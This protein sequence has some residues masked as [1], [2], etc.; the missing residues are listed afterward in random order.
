MYKS[1]FKNRG[2]DHEDMSICFLLLHTQN[3]LM[4]DETPGY[5]FWSPASRAKSQGAVE[6]MDIPQPEE[7]LYSE[8][9]IFKIDIQF[10]NKIGIGYEEL[11]QRKDV[12]RILHSMKVP[13]SGRCTMCIDRK[14]HLHGTVK[15]SET[16]WTGVV[17]SVTCRKTHFTYAGKS[18]IWDGVH[19]NQRY[20]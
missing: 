7:R 1:T 11:K 10:R 8:T 14:R 20:T 13:C 15:N 16:M 2:Y 18:V 9:E 4:K 3:I 6:K 19:T 17:N 12:S 5:F